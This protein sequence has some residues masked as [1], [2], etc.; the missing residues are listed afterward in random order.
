MFFFRYVH[1]GNIFECGETEWDRSFEINVKSMYRMCHAFLPKVNEFMKFSEFLMNF[2]SFQ[3]VNQ[4]SGVIINMSSICSSLKGA[5]RRFA[6]G[7]TK[8][9]VIGLTKSLAIDFVKHGIKVHCICPGT[10]DTPSFRERV[11]AFDDPVQAMEDF[12]GRQ[13]MKKLGTA[14]E[15]A[16]AATFLAS[17]EV[18]THKIS[19]I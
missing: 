9:A 14:D 1:Q 2:L 7:T 17:D 6:Y 8:G 12:I 10:V 3:M 19:I 5:E 15:I 11:Q 4:G 16:A 13:K 18:I